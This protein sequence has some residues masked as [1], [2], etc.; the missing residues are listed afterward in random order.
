MAR[1]VFDRDSLLALPAG[2]SEP[3]EMSEALL[4]SAVLQMQTILAFGTVA[5]FLAGLLLVVGERARYP[6]P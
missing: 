3:T 4:H 6:K 1:V 5:I 2:A